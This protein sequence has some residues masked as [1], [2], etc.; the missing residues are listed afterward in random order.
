MSRDSEKVP[1]HEEALY[2]ATLQKRHEWDRLGNLIFARH[3]E[4]GLKRFAEFALGTEYQKKYID[5]YRVPGGKWTDWP[6]IN[7]S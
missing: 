6:N 7:K 1:G 2:Y 5:T 4:T 3:G